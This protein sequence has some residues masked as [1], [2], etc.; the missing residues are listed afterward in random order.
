[1]SNI[2]DVI[3]RARQPGGFSEQRQFTVARER[4]IRKMRE[5]ALADPHYYILELIQAAVA[6]GATHVHIDCDSSSLKFTYIGG[7][8]SREELAQLFDFLFAS[9]SSLEHADIRQVALGVNALMSMQPSRIIL[10]SGSGTL[11]STDR[12]VVRGDDNT[13]EVGTPDQSL[14]GTFLRAEGLDRTAIAGKSGLEPREYGPAEC[15]AIEQRCLAAPVPII[16]NDEPVFGYSSQRTP[17]VFGYDDV[18][19]FDEGDLY[20]TIGRPQHR[21]KDSFKLL[22]WGCWIESTEAAVMDETKIGGV[23]SYDRLNKTADHSG[24]VRDEHFEQ[25]WAR[26]RPYARQVVEGRSGQ[27]DFH[28]R[29]LGGD[30]LPTRRLREIFRTH[31][32]AVVVTDEDLEQTA[33]PQ[34]AVRIGELLDAPVLR[35]AREAFESVDVLA[36]T[37]AELLRPNLQAPT[38]LDFYARTPVPP[39][40]RPWLTGKLEIDP[41]EVETLADALLAREAVSEQARRQFVD[42]LGTRQPVEGTVYTPVDTED[43]RDLHV[44]VRTLDRAVWEGAVQSPFPGHILEVDLPAVPPSYLRETVDDGE[45]SW[46]QLVAEVVARRALDPLQQATRRSLESLAVS[47]RR[48]SETGRRIALAALGRSALKRLRDKSDRHDRPEV[49]FSLLRSHPGPDLL[50]F[51]LFDTLDGSSVSLRDLEELMDETGGLVY[52]VVPEVEPDL[53]GLDRSRILELDLERE[54]QLL[55]IVGDAAYVRIDQRDVLAET[56]ASRAARSPSSQPVPQDSEASDRVIFQVRDMAL[57]LRSYPEGFPLLVE[58]AD[59]AALSERDRELLVEHLVEQLIATSRD[60]ALDASIRR[61]A[62]RHLQWF[63]CRRTRTDADNPLYGVDRMG[64][65]LD[66]DG[67]PVSFRQVHRALDSRRGIE[68][69]DG[70]SSDVTELGSLSHPDAASTDDDGSTVGELTMNTWVFRLLAPHGTIRGAYDFDFSDAEADAVASTP[71]EAFLAERTLETDRFEGRIGVPAASQEDPAVAVVTDDR[72]HAHRLRRPARTYGVT[73]FVRVK[74][75]EV[76][77]QWRAIRRRVSE[78]AEQIL[79]SLLDSVPDLQPDS[80]AFERSVAVLLGFAARQLQLNRRPDGTIT[81]HI[82]HPLA[83]KILDLPLVPTRTGN[84]VSTLRLLREFSLGHSPD[85]LQR[86]LRLAD[87]LPTPLPAW[88]D[89]HLAPSNV[90]EPADSTPS[91]DPDTS[92]SIDLR[93]ESWLARLRPD[94]FPERLASRDDVPDLDSAQTLVRLHVPQTPRSPDYQIDFADHQPCQ[95]VRDA[96]G[97]LWLDPDHSLVARAR[98]SGDLRDFAWLLLACY[99]H[100]ND[101]LEPITNDH[102]L[103]FQRRVARALDEM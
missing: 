15:T 16:V 57:G 92:A 48:D 35:T 8:Y 27:G 3:S 76:R 9:K 102:E 14:R 103:E 81:P 2:D 70:R 74:H 46:A 43:A 58:G 11:E 62:I 77:D 19:T 54:R 72:S 36:G 21:H 13:V 29:L 34:H 95:Y 61:E 78:A 6:N 59:P 87:P 55:T 25:L 42:H 93:L 79:S 65:F 28:V 82:E 88:L 50:T 84:P 32:R 68:M 49:H 101:V 33:E 85:A 90:V 24:I 80:E 97:I 41:I 47:D 4:A 10:E 37:D 30:E 75:G 56:P 52:G 20:G 100:I 86:R 22:T 39:P 5:F 89:R 51:E 83:Q 45:T 69:I 17:V 96:P 7:G 18:V 38:D 98:S 26:I 71:T 64:L 40:E 73:G 66:G 67:N 60:E 94:D 53:D 44:R 12:I 91:P 1:M 63:V 99:A 31:E 23:I